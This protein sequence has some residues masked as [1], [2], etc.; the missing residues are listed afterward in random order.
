VRL[1]PDLA[2]ARVLL[3]REVRSPVS[4]RIV[5]HNYC[6]GLPPPES[7]SPHSVFRARARL[8][9]RRGCRHSPSRLPANRKDHCKSSD[10]G[11]ARGIR[12]DADVFS[13]VPSRTTRECICTRELQRIARLS[14]APRRMKRRT[15]C[16]PL[17]WKPATLRR[18]TALQ[19]WDSRIIRQSRDGRRA[20]ARRNCVTP[21][22]TLRPACVSPLGGEAE[23]LLPIPQ[24]PPLTPFPSGVLHGTCRISRH[25]RRAECSLVL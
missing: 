5:N 11:R 23:R 24:R 21:R 19:K 12:S 9:L 10:I 2:P 1:D 14:T 18:S 22:A 6:Q 4:D 8:F 16:S 7:L 13:G 17:P 3:L 20:R 25:V 15:S